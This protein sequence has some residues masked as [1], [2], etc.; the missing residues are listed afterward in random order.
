MHVDPGDTRMHDIHRHHHLSQ[1]RHRIP[2]RTRGAH[3]KIK[4]L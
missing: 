2:A 4:I 3:N 1:A